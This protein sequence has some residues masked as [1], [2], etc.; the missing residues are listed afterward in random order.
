M[1]NYS[2][3]Y[4]QW[5]IVIKN[6][7]RAAALFIPSPCLHVSFLCV[8]WCALWFVL[9]NCT[10]FFS[11]FNS[12]LRACVCVCAVSLG[13]NSE[14]SQKLMIWKQ[15]ENKRKKRDKRKNA[16]ANNIPKIVVTN[17]KA[18]NVDIVKKA[19]KKKYINSTKRLFFITIVF[20]S[21]WTSFFF[22]FIFISFHFFSFLSYATR[23]PA[24][25]RS[26]SESPEAQTHST[27][28]TVTANATAAT[29]VSAVKSK[30]I[31]RAN[32][33]IIQ[34][35]SK[36]APNKSLNKFKTGGIVASACLKPVRKFKKFT[37]F[38]KVDCVTTKP[39]LGPHDSPICGKITLKKIKTKFKKKKNDDEI[40]SSQQ[41]IPSTD[42]IA[43]GE[44][45]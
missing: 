33:E 20:H 9:M 38:S 42:W 15:D 23:L 5:W 22:F 43:T 25:N 3:E 37:D 17:E 10:V 44:E 4:L 11:S 31:V 39:S 29:T 16:K 21:N 27:T 24:L 2:R 26:T 1:R 19:R 35:K 40:V 30:A 34:S 32:T 41:S 28:A 45:K 8:V 7:F 18:S 36:N 6:I 14:C 13:W 12:L